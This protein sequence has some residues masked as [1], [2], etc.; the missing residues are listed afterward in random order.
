M[1]RLLKSIIVSITHGVTNDPEV[2]KLIQRYPRAFKF[3]RRR[4]T[5]NEAFGLHLTV[6]VIV[7]LVFVWLFF[8][9][10]QDY[11][12]ND[13]LAQADLRIVSLVQMFRTPLFSAIM[14]V[15]TYLG[16]WQIVG[17]GLLG[18]G[19]ILGLQ[20]RW[21][22][23]VALAVSVGGG[24][25]FIA[26]VKH[27][28]A[29]PRPPLINALV[30]ESS[31]S[32]P[33]GHSFVALSLYGLLAYIIF[34]SV[35]SRW[36]KGITILG[37]LALIGAIGFSRIYLGAHWP[38]DVLASY[39]VGVAWLA[40]IITTLEIQK[41]FF[42]R[43]QKPLLS[44]GKIV[45][46]GMLI[47][48]VWVVSLGYLFVTQPLQPLLAVSAPTVAMVQ[49]DIPEQLFSNLP[50]VS[51]DITGQP[52][53]PVNIIMIGSQAQLANAFLSQG[54]FA[55]DPINPQTVWHLALAALAN[56]PYPHAPGTP[57]FWDARP[58]D[59]AF[60][61]PTAIDSARQ[62][63]HIHFWQTSVV[64]DNQSVWVGTA[65]FDQTVKLKATS[66]LPTHRID[67][68]VDV[69]RDKVKADL[70]ASGLV[71]SWQELKITKPTL[72]SNQAGDPFFTDG[73]AY[74]LLLK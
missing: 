13:P 4:L 10:L 72:G 49:S 26:L 47:A 55:T 60:E 54:W 19:V 34:R 33:S 66:F 62:R 36:L 58:N 45:W 18:G 48:V 20:A 39:A 57:S 70:V 14:L 5:P 68:A 52:M 12:G 25:V 43:E 32:F 64:I 65:H 51:E 59:F 8:G 1:F 61:Q 38:T 53:E 2:Q 37:G 46:V 74:L 6:G 31:Y 3:L 22:Q 67:P 44:A 41:K 63:H 29:R 17:L 28:V 30:Y 11:I 7:T 50:R 16:S 27:F 35:K 40:A 23:V 71:S 69:E 73:N 24:E 21:R 9:V 42:H 56:K 15:V